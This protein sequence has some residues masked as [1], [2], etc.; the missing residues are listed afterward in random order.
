MHLPLFQAL[1]QASKGTRKIRITFKEEATICTDYLS[2][3]S[4]RGSISLN[5]GVEK[6]LM[7]VAQTG[8][9][10]GIYNRTILVTL[11]D[12]FDQNWFVNRMHR[13]L[14][15]IEVVG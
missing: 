10:E 5:N 15:K 8:S 9:W 4:R 1:N 12:K 2:E 11:T 7:A 14:N 3:M 6:I 13:A